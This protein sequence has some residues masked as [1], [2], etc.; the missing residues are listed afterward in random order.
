[1]S[2]PDKST[3]EKIEDVLATCRAY[4]STSIIALAGVPGTGKS[5]IGSIAAQRLATNPLMVREVQFHQSFTYE[6]FIEGLRIDHT[7]AVTVYPGAFLEWND[8]AHDDPEHHYVFLIEELTRKCLR[9][10]R[11]VANLCGAAG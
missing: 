5:H 9:G 7:G 4:G 11:R 3:A 2:T 6:E 10:S 8:Q 1:M